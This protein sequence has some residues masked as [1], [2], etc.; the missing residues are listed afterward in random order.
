MKASIFS[1]VLLM[2][3]VPANSQE[4]VELSETTVSYAPYSSN[5]TNSGNVYSFS[6]NEIYSGEFE[7]NPLTFMKKNFDINRF[8]LELKDK[9][10]DACQVSFVSGKGMLKVDF[11]K[12][13]KMVKMY[14]RFR[15]IKLPNDL[16]HEIYRD[17]KGWNIVK[18]IHVAR[19]R[20]GRIDKEFYRLKLENGNKTKNVRIDRTE[21]TSVELA[22]N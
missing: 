22:I 17:Y 2:W 11:N 19:G 16:S 18:N 12:E 5:L 7:S 9:N 14:Q 4:T 15:N 10:L 21:A 13:G 3:V 1:L 8:I 6:I 20:D